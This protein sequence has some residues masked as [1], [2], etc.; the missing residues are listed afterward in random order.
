MSKMTVLELVQNI[1]SAMDSD[2]VEAT[3]ETEEALQVKSIIVETYRELMARK[4]WN[5]LKLPVPLSAL[6]T[7]IDQDHP[8]TLLIP[9][10]VMTV[11]TVRYDTRVEVG[12]PA[13]WQVIK[14]KEPNDFLDTVL[15]RNSDAD[16]VDVV[17]VVGSAAQIMVFNDRQPSFWT[18]FDDEHITFD[19]YD[20]DLGLFLPADRSVIYATIIPD[21]DVEDDAF[22]PELPA[23][24]FPLFLAE[25]KKACFFYLK[26]ANTPI[27]SQR[28]LR[29]SSVYNNN[30]ARAHARTTRYRFVRK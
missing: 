13:R 28:A 20:S 23:R 25:C 27:D 22:V 7:T 11:D 26:E 3:D 6:D 19:A 1:L 29:Q 24:M 14:W 5:H 8:T 12:D 4:D 21:F 9:T 2:V 17:D 16:E 15:T 30:G 18:S 10:N